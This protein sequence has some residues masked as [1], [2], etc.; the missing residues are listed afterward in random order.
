MDGD[1]AGKRL[2]HWEAIYEQD[3]TRVSWYQPEPTTSLEL[4][5]Q[6]EVA[7]DSA[8]VDV[9][10]GASTLVD[11]LTARGF[12]DLS[13]L[14]VSGAALEVARQ[15]LGSAA[16]RISWLQHDLLQWTPSRRYDL[17]HDRAVFHFLVDR[18]DQEQYRRLLADTLSWTGAAIIATFAADGPSHCSGLPV[19]RYEPDQLMTMLA[20]GYERVASR[21]DDHTTPAGVVQPFAWVAFRRTTNG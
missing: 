11:A 7:T 19:A 8:I 20:D 16:E 18:S 10:G 9:G 3:P 4:I 1:R 21:R 2:R 14:D 5:D 13:V 12:G 6:L 15:R 17:W